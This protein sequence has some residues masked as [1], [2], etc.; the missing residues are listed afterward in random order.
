[1]G[2]TANSNLDFLPIIHQVKKQFDDPNFLNKIN[3]GDMI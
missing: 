3:P 1:M 2:K